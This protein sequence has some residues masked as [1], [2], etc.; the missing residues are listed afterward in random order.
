[1][2]TIKILSLLLMMSSLVCSSLV[3]QSC[4]SG[5]GEV[6]PQGEKGDKGDK[7]D[8]G[9]TGATGATGNA[10]VIQIT[11]GSRTHE[12]TEINYALTGVS[13]E[14]LNRSAYFTYV[15]PGG[16]AFWYSL[17]GT[18]VGGSREYRTYVSRDMATPRL[19]INRVS[20]SAGEV[21]AST[22][23]IIIPASNLINGRR[24][25]IDFNNY[26]QV[27]KYYGLPE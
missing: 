1:M 10:N 5:S 2:K 11:F 16:S 12:G 15:N 13:L 24:P 17:P 19:Y 6:G 20:G 25:S 9:A 26:E 3:F 21:F 18:T 7:G 23:V 27:R 8:T 4:K 14:V 22:R